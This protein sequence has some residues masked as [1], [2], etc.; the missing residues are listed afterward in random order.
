M[1]YFHEKCEGK[2]SERRT[3]RQTN[4][5]GNRERETATETAD[6]Q[7][8]R[9][10]L[11]D[12]DEVT[13]GSRGREEKTNKQKNRPSLGGARIRLAEVEV[14]T[15]ASNHR[16][17]TGLVGNEEGRKGVTCVRRMET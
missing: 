14:E 1:V 16:F 10:R 2:E 8:K 13:T 4:E 6:R 12:R 17:F 15:D 11:R 7:T 9:E 5:E 3:G